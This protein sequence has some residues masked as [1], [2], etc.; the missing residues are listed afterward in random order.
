M[1]NGVGMAVLTYAGHVSF[2]VNMDFDYRAESGQLW[3][4]G[5]AGRLVSAFEKALEELLSKAKD[6]KI[7]HEAEERVKRERMAFDADGVVGKV[8]DELTKKVD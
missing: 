6:M 5:D 7:A 3:S 4:D 2:G 1:P 8:K